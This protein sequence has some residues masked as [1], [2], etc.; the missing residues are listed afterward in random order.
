MDLNINGRRALV[1]GAST[2]IGAGVA[3]ALAREGVLLALSAQSMEAL[4]KTATAIEAEGFEKPTL[5]PASLTDAADTIRLSQEA[6]NA[7]GHI[8]I[9][10]N[11]AGGS[12]PTPLDADEAFWAEAFDLNFHAPR[13][14]THALLPTMQSNQWGRIINISGSMEPR[15][16]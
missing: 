2:G 1:T 13:R 10:A 9:L 16:L 4:S 3:I 12:R 14:L 11:C 15:S 8:D 7:L 5:I 6:T